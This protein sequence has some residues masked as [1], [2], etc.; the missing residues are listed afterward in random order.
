MRRL[1]AVVLVLAAASCLEQE[2]SALVSFPDKASFE[3]AGVSA[4]MER[5]CGALDCHGQSGRPLKIYSQLGLRLGSG[6][7]GARDVSATTP[8]EI[9]ANYRSVVGLEPESIGDAVRTQG[10]YIDF[11]LLLKPLDAAGGGVRHEGGPVL[12]ISDTDPGWVCLHGWIAGRP[13]PVQCKAATF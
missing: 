10:A 8:A 11:Q 13:D 12:R 6:P 5:R 1:F 3:S 2:E 9:D 4:F 7:G